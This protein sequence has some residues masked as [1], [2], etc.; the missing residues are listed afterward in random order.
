MAAQ[1]Q[2]NSLRS[3]NSEAPNFQNPRAN[4]CGVG[5][6]R[7]TTFRA[8]IP[9][10]KCCVMRGTGHQS[11]GGFLSACGLRAGAQRWVFGAL[12]AGTFGALV[13]AIGY[14][15]EPSWQLFST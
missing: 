7:A 1:M 14:G 13:M 12:A 8:A 2:A 3:L 4:A 11:L 5:N 6:A 9:A 15:I 10:L